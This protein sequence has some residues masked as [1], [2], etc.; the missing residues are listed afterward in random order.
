MG[1]AIAVMPEPSRSVPP[2]PDFTDAEGL[3]ALL[4]RLDDADGW[5]T[6]ATVPA[7]VCYLRGKYAQL[8]RK[9]DRDPDEAVSAAFVVL[10]AVATRRARDPWAVVTDAVAKSLKAEAH[11]EWLMIST[12]K[13][14][15]PG[16][17]EHDRPVRASGNEEF[18]T[19][20][21]TP[22][23]DDGHDDLGWLQD[24]LV[25]VLAGLGWPEQVADGCVS[26][27]LD[28]VIRAGRR[29]T[30]FDALRRDIT[31]AVLYEL[32]REAWLTL[33]R[34]LL[35][36]GGQ[37]AIGARRGMIARLLLGESAADL[38]GDD[39]M[40]IALAEAAPRAGWAS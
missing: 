6:D 29:E 40:V 28:H 16:Q 34:A 13:A 17:V 15:R 38:L 18:L 10:R 30:A 4:T 31:M 2:A 1:E 32:P 25:G 39:A 26:Y 33:L 19:R 27:V 9:W 35:G 3:R 21:A 20:L 12:E 22:A 37:V 14:R 5:R 23:G 8:A 11:A 7:L 24:T 36:G